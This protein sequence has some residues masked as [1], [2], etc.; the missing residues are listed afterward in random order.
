M[1]ECDVI[2]I[3][4]RQSDYHFTD[5]D[6]LYDAPNHGFGWQFEVH[7]H[8][9]LLVFSLLILSKAKKNSKGVHENEQTIIIFYIDSKL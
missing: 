4:L 9:E 1:T 2:K 7:T 8:I 3:D 5:R 6:I